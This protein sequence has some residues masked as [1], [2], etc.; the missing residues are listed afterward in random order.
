MLEIY[1]KAQR[2]TARI[3]ICGRCIKESAEQIP[4]KDIQAMEN[5][6]AL[7]ELEK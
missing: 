7:K 3:N 2:G 6:I 4:D 5:R 1:K